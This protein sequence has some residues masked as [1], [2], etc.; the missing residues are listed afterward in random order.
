MIN[1]RKGTFETNSSSS[2]SLVVCN[3]ETWLDFAR[4]KLFY[5]VLHEE[6]DLPEFCTLK[7]IK[8]HIRRLYNSLQSVKFGDF[9]TDKAELRELHHKINELL[10]FGETFYSIDELEE[11]D[12]NSDKQ[13]ASLTYYFG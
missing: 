4:G 13:E 6:N 8:L 3:E 2:H 7:D 5:N 1:I 12:Y 9:P 11:Y 10:W